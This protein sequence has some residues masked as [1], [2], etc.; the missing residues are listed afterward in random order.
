MTFNKI[1]EIAGNSEV[2]FYSTSGIVIIFSIAF[3]IEAL[4][5][6]P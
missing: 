6:R 4:K 3:L 5:P 1:I 2:F